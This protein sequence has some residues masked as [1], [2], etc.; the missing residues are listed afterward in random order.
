MWRQKLLDNNQSGYNAAIMGWKY[1][2][3]AD[4]KYA[5]KTREQTTKNSYSY[6]HLNISAENSLNELE[7]RNQVT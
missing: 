5:L 7:S 6:E 1:A 4:I 3:K 2:L